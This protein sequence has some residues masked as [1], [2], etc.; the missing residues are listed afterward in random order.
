MNKLFRRLGR[1]VR[2]N[3][4][5]ASPRRIFKDILAASGVT[6]L[7]PRE[8]KVSGVRV[9][10]GTGSTL[11]ADL[12]LSNG[13]IIT[14]DSASSTSEAVA[15]RG[16]KI[17]AVG[18]TADLEAR[19]AP[20]TRRINLQ[21]QTLLPG[22][23]DTHPHM[24][25]E[26]LKTLGGASLIGA[27]S[28]S[29]IVERV[30]E[31]ATRAKPGEWLV[32]MPMGGPPF[33]Y[34]NNPSMLKE[35]RFPNRYDL[36]EAAP[37]NPVFIR[38]V[39][40]WWARPPF[41][42]V[43]NSE[44]LRRCDITA[45][46]VDP[47]NIKIVRDPGGLPTGLF[48]ETN[49][50]SLL[51]YTLFRNVPRFTYEDRLESVRRSSE[52][53]NSSGTTSAY[54]AHGLTPELLR[55]YREVDE[56]GE[57][58]VRMSAAV[59]LPSSS[60]NR[61][62][63]ID[64]LDQW[65]PSAGGRGMASGNFR[66][67]GVTLDH[68]DPKIAAIIAKDYPYVQ[69]AGNFDQGITTSE[70]VEIGIEAA[71]RKLRLNFLIATHPPYHSVDGTLDML[72]E[73]DKQAPLRDLRCVGFHLINANA[74]QLRRVRDLGL[75]I[76]MTPSFIYSHAAEL[77][78]GQDACPIREVLDAGIPVALGTDNVPPSMFFTAWEALARWDESGQRQLGDSRLDR[79]EVLRLCCQSPHYI[80]WEED[81]RG[82]IA[83]GMAAEFMVLDANPL[84]CDIDLL[85][86]LA[87]VLTVVDGRIVHDAGVLAK[88]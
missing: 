17:V 64:L 35:G 83:P 5:T 49:R 29:A 69:W 16:S 65:A 76:T 27:N 11:R 32:F 82:V 79:E 21:G 7:L 37:D 62:R 9:S 1:F 57:L 46:S 63:L 31:A 25:R 78:L 67:F 44:A 54:E 18:K 73:I 15:V 34:V 19:V 55:A 42:A 20:D 66:V 52:I 14:L 41:P 33:D 30:A 87:P 39:W 48:L 24:D 36:D 74:Q 23:F 85:P 84:T 10:S 59:S 53:Y 68:T 81:N 3:T 61:S 45:A 43:A 80:N 12:L 88:A 22:F 60:M 72:E 77:R 6:A 47:Y 71:R 4:S 38:G 56:R 40:G 75:I 51:E 70:F 28:V 58:S 13:N 2:W 50:T 26:G 86:Q 8:K